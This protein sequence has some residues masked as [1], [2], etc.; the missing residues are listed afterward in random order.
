M[1]LTPLFED[2]DVVAV[3]KPPGLLTHPA[4]V[5][6]IAD[7]ATDAV[8]RA[9]EHTHLGVHQRLDRD[10]SGIL[11]FGCSADADR[12]LARSFGGHEATKTYNAVVHGR[13]RQASGTIEL[14]LS[15]PGP[16]GR[17]SVVRGQGG[18]GSNHAL[19]RRGD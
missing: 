16:E 14:H 3:V 10:T 9:S 17:V 6:S 19:S 1:Y 2:D 8:R 5:D 7:S 15:P 11:L 12:G 13:P 18:Q 4:D